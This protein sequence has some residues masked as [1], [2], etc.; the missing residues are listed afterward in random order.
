[1]LG[2]AQNPHNKQLQV[3]PVFSLREEE[4]EMGRKGGIWEA[5]VSKIIIKIYEQ[6]ESK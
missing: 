5:W 1:M 2:V 6:F 4:H 3:K